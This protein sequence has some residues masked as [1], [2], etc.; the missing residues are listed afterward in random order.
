MTSTFE[1]L[2]AQFAAG[3]ISRRE[4]IGRAA[5]LGALAAVPAGL[6]AQ[7]A[8]AAGPQK[9]GHLRAATVQGSTT[10]TLDSSKLTSG[11]TSFL[12]MTV[13]SQLT[14]VAPDGSLIPLLAE[15]FEPVDADPAKWLFVL[16]D[17]VE[18]HNGKTV[19]ADDVIISIDRHRG[20]DS[21]SA[22]KSFAETIVDM[23]KDGERGVIFTL[24]EGNVDFPFVLSA[25]QLSIHPTKDGQP[26]DFGVGS[27]AYVLEN[28]TAG[29]KANLTRNPNFFMPDRAH[30]ESA[31]I[32]T[33]A[34]PA[35]RTNALIT[36]AVDFIGDV[37]AKTA[38][39][40][41]RQSGV[42]LDQV[43]GGQHYTFPMRTTD[44]PF[45][46]VDV[47]LA[48]KHAIDR[49]EVLRKIVGGRGTLGNDHP[50]SP[51]DRFYNADLPQRAYDPD[52]ARH[53]LQKAGLDGLK[54]RLSAADGLYSGAVDTAVLYAEQAKKAGIDIEVN[55]V[56]NDGY[57]SNVWMQHP[58]CASYW[59]GRPTADWMF[60]QGYS[61]DS[62]WNES[63]WANARFNELLKAARAQ[64]DED[65]RRGMYHDMQ[66]L[67][68]DD[69]GS[70]VHLFANHIMAYNDNVGRPQKVAGNW[71]FDGYK[72]IE[73]WW[74]KS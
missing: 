32:L 29:Q 53:H 27:G 45:D 7:E 5:V 23:K 34:D 1:R 50:I 58:W 4:F 14:E 70:V 39:L 35:A 47:R 18:F 11:M 8:R 62:S 42:T 74:I 10:D 12:F 3:R 46:N 38:H 40:M 31:E 68:R 51:N 60:T 57:W 66:E 15:S 67:C 6:M 13:Y 25:Q 30:V 20:E 64:L 43:T 16:R 24:Q 56:P 21:T 33:I 61:A 65:K 28:F 49:E 19:D 52:L 36:K 17:G 73:R 69:G 48:L 54:V 71:E 72:M 26:T 9:G 63:Y 59:A 37:E 22:M 2:Q 41:E 44:A 55:R